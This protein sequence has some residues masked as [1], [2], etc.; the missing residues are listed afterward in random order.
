[1]AEQ[2]LNGLELSAFHHVSRHCR[3]RDIGSNGAPLDTAF[4]LRE[5]EEYLS[6]NWLE[7][8]AGSN[9]R[10]QVDSVRRALTA[11]GFRVAGTS[12]FAVLN[13]G[14][15][16]AEFRDV[17]G[18]S[19]RIIALGENNDPSH[20]GIYGYAAHNVAGAALLAALVGPDDVHPAYG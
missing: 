9:R 18:I 4:R 8:V 14:R 10:E 7:R 3:R 11:K 6:T 19:I 20:T 13:V 5:G 17:L 15:A 12:S 1:M 2:G 16:V